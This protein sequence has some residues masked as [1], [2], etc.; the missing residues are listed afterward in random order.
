M[1]PTFVPTWPRDET[2]YISHRQ[3]PG[4]TGARCK[5]R[6]RSGGQGGTGPNQR[7]SSGQVVRHSSPYEHPTFKRPFQAKIPTLLDLPRFPR[8]SSPVPSAPSESTTH[9]L[10]SIKSIRRH[11]NP[12]SVH[13][14]PSKW[15]PLFVPPPQRWPRWPPRALARPLSLSSSRSSPV[16]T[17]VRAAIELPEL[18]ESLH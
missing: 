17:L 15:P 2:L 13:H 5:R 7:P 14:I 8:D 12:S 11:L 18:D 1:D 6:R 10:R 3:P 4:E 16:H 9:Q